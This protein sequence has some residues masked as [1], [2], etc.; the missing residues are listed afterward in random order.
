MWP[1]PREGGSG[2][3]YDAM[4][5]A[6]PDPFAIQPSGALIVAAPIALKIAAAARRSSSKY[7]PMI[8]NGSLDPLFE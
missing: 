3:S 7:L 2:Q 6:S 1:A 5:Q 4:M 8:N